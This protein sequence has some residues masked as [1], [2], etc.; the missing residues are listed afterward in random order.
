VKAGDKCTKNTTISCLVDNPGSAKLFFDKCVGKSSDNVTDQCPKRKA[1]TALQCNEDKVNPS[2]P[3]YCEECKLDGAPCANDTECCSAYFSIA[4][5]LNFRVVR[6]S[7]KCLRG[8]C[9]GCIPAGYTC[10]DSRLRC[11]D[12]ITRPNA[13]GYHC[14]HDVWYDAIYPPNYD[15]C[16]PNPCIPDLRTSTRYRQ[17]RCF[18]GKD[19]NYPKKYDKV[20]FCK[21]PKNQITGYRC[22]IGC[23]PKCIECGLDKSP[24]ATKDDCCDYHE[25]DTE[26][27]KCKQKKC[28]L[29]GASCAS[30]A[31]CGKLNCLRT[32]KICTQ[33]VCKK[34]NE[35]CRGSFDCCEP[36]D[37]LIVNGKAP[38]CL[39]HPNKP[40]P[41]SGGEPA[42]GYIRHNP[43]PIFFVD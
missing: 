29:E 5:E 36:L 11:C 8:V 7:A 1:L 35:S 9:T 41:G 28:S 15:I 17:T 4:P 37:C 2:K 34:V 32:F 21:C 40:K 39:V 26:T 20:N 25:C 22:S 38:I 6:V 10:K 19:Q 13:K 12:E 16:G 3:R 33:D 23:E 43:P 42:P 24:C 14:H 18:A 31:C 30:V 27:Q